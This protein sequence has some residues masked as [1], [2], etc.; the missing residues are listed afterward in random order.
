MC[1]LLITGAY[2]LIK[3]EGGD[4]SCISPSIFNL[5]QRI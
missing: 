1:V 2:N 4:A 5:A 3:I